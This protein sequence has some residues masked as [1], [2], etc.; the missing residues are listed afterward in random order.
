MDAMISDEHKSDSAHVS[1]PANDSAPRDGAADLARYY[2]LDAIDLLDDLPIFLDLASTADGPI[3][4][5]AAG[6]GRLAVPMALAGHDL[7]CVDNDPAMLE[8]AHL[9]WASQADDDGPGSLETIAGDMRTF[10]SETRFGFVFV[11]INTLLL[12][13]DDASRLAVL[14]TAAANLQPGG[15]L[16][17]DVLDRT[18]E[19]IDDYDGRVLL[20][21]M[22]IDRETGE[23]V[24]KSMSA[25][26][27]P[28]DDTI[29]LV[30]IFD[31]FPQSGGA[32]RRV[33]RTDVLHLID[34]TRWQALTERA[35]F[36]GVK[37]WGDYRL[38]PH[39]ARSHRALI[40]ARLL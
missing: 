12:M 3:L 4:E 20:E 24:T 5:L 39:G 18:A 15:L 33:A 9:G 14:E 25:R 7:V 13:P 16:V 17:I 28:D 29:T 30:Q 37:L 31:A 35:G 32:V 6:S 27:D 23:Q 8:R 34:A 11:A 38:G 19:E 22:R 21:W 2:D 26:H 36:G 10:R 40:E 1:A